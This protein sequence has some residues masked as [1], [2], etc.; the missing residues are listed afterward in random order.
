MSLRRLTKR[1]QFVKAARGTRV[2]RRGFV[3]QAATVEQAIPGVG[4]TVTK[5]TGNAPERNRIKRRLRAAVAKV[6]GKLVA[7]HDYVLIGRREALNEP[8]NVL[9]AELSGSIERIHER[10]RPKGERVLK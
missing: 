10:Q 6:S 7:G 2:A 1:A 4:Y 5:K 3:L 8:F 9:V